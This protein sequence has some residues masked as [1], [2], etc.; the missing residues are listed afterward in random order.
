MTIMLMMMMVMVMVMCGGGEER[1][2][3]VYQ[4]SCHPET[5][6][7]QVL[8]QK[9]MTY[10]GLK[11]FHLGHNLLVPPVRD[12]AESS[13]VDSGNARS[14]QNEPENMCPHLAMSCRANE[15]G[16]NEE[17]ERERRYREMEDLGGREEKLEKMKRVQVRRRN[18]ERMQ[19]GMRC[20]EV[21]YLG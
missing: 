5:G 10:L 20:P 14:Q 11:Q 8:C 7:Y 12:S 3:K 18:K 4:L 2:R 17:R 13:A 1:P 19:K 16:K 21:Q 6:K 9:R 15:S